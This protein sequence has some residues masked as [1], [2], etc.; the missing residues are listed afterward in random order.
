MKLVKFIFEAP[1]L[2]L[3]WCRGLKTNRGRAGTSTSVGLQSHAHLHNKGFRYQD[4][5]VHIRR[6]PKRTRQQPTCVFVRRK[7]FRGFVGS[8]SRLVKYFRS[9]YPYPYWIQEFLVKG[10]IRAGLSHVGLI[11]RIFGPE[12]GSRGTDSRETDC[13][14][15]NFWSR[16]STTYFEATYSEATYY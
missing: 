16:Q 3:C 12:S 5:G 7:C 14:S 15:N 4:C 10:L 1:L 6:R 2:V 9:F 11:R 8:F 13:E